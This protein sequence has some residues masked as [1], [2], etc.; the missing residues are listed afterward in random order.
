M[1]TDLDALIARLLE[2]KDCQ[3]E[4]DRCS[5]GSGPY[6]D[7]HYFNDE[8]TLILREAAAALTDLRRQV[9]E[10]DAHDCERWHAEAFGCAMCNEHAGSIR[11]QLAEKGLD[12]HKAVYRLERAECALAE[13]E[14][15]LAAVEQRLRQVQAETWEQAAVWIAAHDFSS[16]T[17][18]GVQV[19]F[20][21]RAKAARE[22]T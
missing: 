8:F 16:V 11:Q 4:P 5:L 17:N 22:G 3:D 20:R 9:T 19:E 2:V 7:Y 1:S 14:E 13:A 15:A 10:Q 12:W 6:C 21:R 18:S